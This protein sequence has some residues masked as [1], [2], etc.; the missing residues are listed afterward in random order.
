MRTFF[1]MTF[2][3]ILLVV[4]YTKKKKKKKSVTSNRCIFSIVVILTNTKF[5]SYFHSIRMKLM[6]LVWF[7]HRKLCI[8]QIN[9]GIQFWNLLTHILIG[10]CR[11]NDWIEWEREKKKHTHMEYA[12]ACNIQ[13]SFVKRWEKDFNQ[14]YLSASHKQFSNTIQFTIHWGKFI[15][16]WNDSIFFGSNANLLLLIR[17]VCDSFCME[18]NQFMQSSISAETITK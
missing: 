8:E 13:S 6:C 15:F 10:K 9:N 12:I 5:T 4:E 16:L 17:L 14:S 3:V 7:W 18:Y 1:L 11:R 2:D